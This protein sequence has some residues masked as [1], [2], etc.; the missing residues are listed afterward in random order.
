MFTHWQAYST[1][2]WPLSVPLVPLVSH[3][4]DGALTPVSNHWRVKDDG[5]F[6]SKADI[7]SRPRHVRY[8]P[9]SGH[10]SARFAR[11]L[12]AI[13]GHAPRSPRSPIRPVL[14]TANTNTRRHSND[15]ARFLRVCKLEGWLLGP[16]LTSGA[17]LVKRASASQCVATLARDFAPRGIDV[18]P[19]YLILVRSVCASVR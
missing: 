13:S 7:A 5:R 17:N 1:S 6:G 19:D 4:C 2:L 10:S 12:S 16:P 14:A 9:Q 3:A 15:G 18:I 11:P 8:S